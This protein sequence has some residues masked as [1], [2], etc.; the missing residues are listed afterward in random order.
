MKYGFIKCAAACVQV[1]ISDPTV[2]AERIVRQVRLSNE[3]GVKLL[4]FPE[5]SLTGC[6]CA[7][8]FYTQALIDG[9]KKALCDVL[10]Q[11]ADCDVAFVVGLPVRVDSKLYDCAAVCHKGVLLGLAPKNYISPTDIS[12][13]CFTPGDGKNRVLY[14]FLEGEDGCVVG[15]PFGTDIVFTAVGVENFKFGVVIGDDDSGCVPASVSLCTAGA[16]IIANPNSVSQTVYS[17]A[18]MA[19]RVRALSDSLICGYVTAQP[20]ETES[21][22]NVIYASDHVIAECSKILAQNAPFGDDTVTVTDIDVEYISSRRMRNAMYQERSRL[23]DKDNECA[24]YEFE[25]DISE[26][27]LDRRFDANPFIPSDFTDADA[28]RIVSIQV[29]ALY[30]RMLC[31]KPKTLVIGVSGGLDSTLALLVC[32]Y[33]S[34]LYGGG[35]ELITA[36]SMPCFGTGTRTRSNTQLLADSLGIKLTTVDITDSVKKHFDDIGLPDTDRGA[37]FENAQARERTQVLMDIANKDGGFVV[38]TGDLSELALGFCT[39]N[40]DH[41]SM[42][43]VN[44]SIPKTLMRRIVAHEAEKAMSGGNTTL[45]DVLNDILDTPISPELLPGEDGRIG[46]MTEQILGPYELHDFFIYYTVHLGYDRDKTLHIAKYA[47]GD[48]YT[49]EQIETTYSVFIKRF[50]TQQF[51]RACAPDG[52]SAT[53][54]SF[55]PRGDCFMPSEA[56]FNLFK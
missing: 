54:V 48:R 42:Y 2:N 40:G 50:F 33:A 5:L 20:H 12:R 11:T 27:I 51:K 32:M 18:R 1:G 21:T 9:A 13:R 35:G 28:E 3:A 10:T 30:R 56:S 16:K 45:A 19:E 7:D 44:S 15:V 22:Q 49:S 46:Q 52:I 31:V 4:V 38:G 36:V 55:N 25:C 47:L 24:E 17:S 43:S 6:T 8:L 53:D 34:R 37:A 29:H 26:N 41:M 23:F 14:R 39:Y